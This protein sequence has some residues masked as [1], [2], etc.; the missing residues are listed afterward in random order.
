[1]KQFFKVCLLVSLALVFIA[2]T[3]LAWNPTGQMWVKTV[4]AASDTNDDGGL[5]T[6]NTANTSTAF[7]TA[8]Q[9]YSG[10]G[11]R[12]DAMPQRLTI[13]VVTSAI[14][15]SASVTVTLQD[16]PDNTNWATLKSLTA[17]S[18]VGVVAYR[19]GAQ[20]SDLPEAFGKYL[21]ISWTLDAGERCSFTVLGVFRAG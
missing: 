21:R 19:T 3:A 20:S 12:S 6:A 15:T 10:E 2:S 8:I 11:N 9:T 4:V 7:N 1:M 13:Y 14:S 5:K 18:A 17:I 16:S